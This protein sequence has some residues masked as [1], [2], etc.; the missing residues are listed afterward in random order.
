MDG[1]QQRIRGVVGEDDERCARNSQRW[2][3]HLL[4]HLPLPI[5]VTGIEDFPWEELY[6]LGG[7][8]KGEYE[9]LKK[10]QTELAFENPLFTDQAK[11]GIFIGSFVAGVAGYTLLRLKPHRDPG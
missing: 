10:T 5:R 2:R 1:W 8:D 6:V 3:S 7:W 9:E 4:K 11:I